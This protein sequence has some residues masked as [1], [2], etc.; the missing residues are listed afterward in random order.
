MATTPKRQFGFQ[1][2]LTLHPSGV[3]S[4]CII[5][6]R[7]IRAAITECIGG[8]TNRQT[9]RQTNGRDHLTLRRYPSDG[10]RQP[11]HACV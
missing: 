1:K 9:D 10:A 2:Y 4:V 5:I 8:Q 6:L 3:G 11:V 7:K